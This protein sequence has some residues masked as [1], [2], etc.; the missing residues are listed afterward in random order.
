MG[1][2]TLIRTLKHE[3]GLTFNAY[4]TGGGEM[5]LRA[6]TET[7]HWVHLTDAADSL[8][9][10]DLREQYG[11]DGVVFGYGVSVFAD[12]ECSEY[13]LGTQEYDSNEDCAADRQRQ[14]R[15][16]FMEMTGGLFCEWDARR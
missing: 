5:C 14:R 16:A 1:Y 12:D 13:V 9:H 7:G 4:N 6:V 11:R 8:S 2:D 10:A 15:P 3:F